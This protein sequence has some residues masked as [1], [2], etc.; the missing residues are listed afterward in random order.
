VVEGAV[1][2]LGTGI[3][4][5]CT[6]PADTGGD[7]WLEAE[8]ASARAALQLGLSV[9]DVRDVVVWRPEITAALTGDAV[10]VTWAPLPAATDPTWAPRLSMIGPELFDSRDLD[11]SATSYT[12]LLEDLEDSGRELG[13]SAGFVHPERAGIYSLHIAWFDAPPAAPIVPRSRGAACRLV[14]RFESEYGDG[15]L[16]EPVDYPAGGC[17]LVDGS[18][19]WVSCDEAV[20]TCDVV[21]GT[22]DLGAV[23]PVRRVRV[24]GETEWDEHTI[25]TSEDGITYTTLDA[26]DPLPAPALARYV[27]INTEDSLFEISVF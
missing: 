9:T 2:D 17:P 12:F 11:P 8:I 24:H 22:I 16:D 23:V 25:S 20:A 1:A 14:N 19:V 4:F 5:T 3:D 26:Y 18:L 15:Y 13:V 27:R 6:V 10:A 21:E 7:A